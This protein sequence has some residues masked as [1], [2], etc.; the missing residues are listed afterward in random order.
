MSYNEK[1]AAINFIGD[2]NIQDVVGLTVEKIELDSM[3]IVIK[4]TNG[5][6]FSWYDNE[7]Y[8]A[9]NEKEAL[10]FGYVTQKDINDK[11]QLSNLS[12]IKG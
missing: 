4:F 11:R 2:D 9:I 7:L 6:F 12:K 10:H 1:I 8:N 3:E 5:T